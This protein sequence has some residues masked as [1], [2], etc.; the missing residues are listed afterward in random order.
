M[1]GVIFDRDGVLVSNVGPDG[2]APR[3]LD[4]LRPALDL[5][6]I[7]DELAAIGI[8]TSVVTC[9]PGV[10]RGLVT[11]N[12]VQ[13][14]NK[15]LSAAAPALGPFFVCY[16]D[17]QD[18]CDCRKPRPGLLKA[19]MHAMNSTPEDTFVVGDRWVDVA[20][21][22]ATGCLSVL[23]RTRFDWRRSS[24]DLMPLGLAPDV[25]IKE[26]RDLIEVVRARLI[27]PEVGTQSGRPAPAE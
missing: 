21:A 7:I 11:K 9:Q 15:A 23:L 5:R 19:A 22:K 8:P 2:R 14:M 4:E 6:H 17:T 20:A 26:L 3:S 1:P 10:A 25:E 13:R 12:E 24:T 27:E 16:H 18:G